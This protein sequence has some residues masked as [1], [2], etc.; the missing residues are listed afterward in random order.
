MPHSDRDLLHFAKPAGYNILGS[1]QK[2]TGLGCWSTH[3]TNKASNT[4]LA[5]L[6]FRFV[7]S[8][9]VVDTVDLK[10]LAQFWSDPPP[11]FRS[12]IYSAKKHGFDVIEWHVFEKV[13]GGMFSAR[14][15]NMHDVAIYVNGNSAWSA[16]R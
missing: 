9:P 14:D 3:R 7:S 8:P 4:G 6:K 13:L 1:S 11:T 16:F 10:P 2:P 12:S 5:C 15:V